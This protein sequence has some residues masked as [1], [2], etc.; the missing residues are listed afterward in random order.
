ML[1]TAHPHIKPPIIRPLNVGDTA[2]YRVLRQKILAIG[3]GRYFSDSYTREAAL[4][5]QQWL[6]WC[7]E[8]PE[9]CIL[10]M[11][12]NGHLIGTMMATQLGAPEELTVEWEAIW[13]D[14]LYR[15]QGIAK[16]AYEQ[17]EQWTLD[18]GYDRVVLYIR[19]DNA[20]SQEIHRKQGAIYTHT[21]H[22][23]VWADGSVADTHCF[24]LRLP[25]IPSIGANAH[26]NQLPVFWK[27]P[28]TS[29]ST[30][31][32]GEKRACNER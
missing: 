14:P 3:D 18:Q 21:K 17:V 26:Y 6:N 12:D 23:E 25:S 31:K 8:T 27:T 32:I 9:H 1:I 10:G 13:L 30:N 20:R 29:P 24:V 5:E 22:N 28:Y 15:K 4:N 11:F 16:N 7:T 19:A 2:A